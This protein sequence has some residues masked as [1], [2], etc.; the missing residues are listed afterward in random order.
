MKKLM[1]LGTMLV[2][3]LSSCQKDKD[4]VKAKNSVNAV[5][6]A[7]LVVPKDFDWKT[8][9]LT[10][11]RIEGSDA[12]FTGKRPIVIKTE[13]DRLI[14]SRHVGMNEDVDIQ[15]ELPIAYKQIKVEYGAITKLVD[16]NNGMASFDF[17]PAANEERIMDDSENPQ[18]EV[19]LIKVDEE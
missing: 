9:R 10:T 17:V 16:V 1:L 8:T 14:L 15:F 12:M 18:P 7:D 19:E 11:L 3:A 4:Q 6:T 2:L 13:D 5:S